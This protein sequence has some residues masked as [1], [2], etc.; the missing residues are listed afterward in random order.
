[1]I[2]LSEI[3]ANGMKASA[4][5][6]KTLLWPLPGGTEEN[7]DKSQS[8]PDREHDRLKTRSVAFEPSCQAIK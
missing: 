1:M 4:T 2:I 8:C 7:H 6:L 5:S 3:E